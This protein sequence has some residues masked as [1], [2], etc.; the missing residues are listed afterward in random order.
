MV[1]WVKG[2][3][4]R[5][6]IPGARRRVVAAGRGR[7]ATDTLSASEMRRFGSGLSQN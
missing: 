3:G 6:R 5:G 2:R 4:G 1:R 7:A